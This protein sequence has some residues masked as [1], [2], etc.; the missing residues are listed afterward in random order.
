MT[1]YGATSPNAGGIMSPFQGTTP[2]VPTG[3]S[4]TAL[5]TG[6][7]LLVA[8]SLG[9]VPANALV[10]TVNGISVGA[11]GT[12]GDPVT[13]SELLCSG[14]GNQSNLGTPAPPSGGANDQQFVQGIAQ[15]AATLAN[16]PSQFNMEP[17]TIGPVS[18]GVFCNNVALLASGFGG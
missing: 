11:Q 16:G 8:A 9:L 17:Q 6:M 3:A 13:V 2:G 12:G 18:G 4:L 10:N 5:P 15:T 14:N 1:L 7:P